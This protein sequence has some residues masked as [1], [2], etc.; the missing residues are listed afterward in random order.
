MTE[1]I[2]SSLIIF[3]DQSEFKL[4]VSMLYLQKNVITKGQTYYK[5]FFFQFNAKRYTSV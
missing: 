1:I 4:V 5:A 2:S 3:K